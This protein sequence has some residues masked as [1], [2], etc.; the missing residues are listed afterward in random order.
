MRKG[1][2]RSI[3]VGCVASLLAVGAAHTAGAA[4]GDA[5]KTVKIMVIAE[6]GDTSFAFL[7]GVQKG[8]DAAVKAIEKAGT[9]KFDVTTCDAHD[10]VNKLDECAQ[11]AVDQKFAAVFALS[12]SQGQHLLPILEKGK[13]PTFWAATITSPEENSEISMLPTS[14]TLS[15][16]GALGA[17]AAINGFKK[18]AVIM[19]N[20]LAKSVTALSEATYAAQGGKLAGE[21]DIPIT[22]PG[23]ANAPDLAPKAAAVADKKPGVVLMAAAGVNFVQPL[24]EAGVDVP[25]FLVQSTGPA[26]LNDPLDALPAELTKNIYKVSPFPPFDTA[27][28]TK[29]AKQFKKEL[30]AIG[31]TESSDLSPY[32]WNIWVGVHALAEVVPTMTGTIDGTTTLAAL[33]SAKDVKLVDG[34]AWTPS[35]P[36]PANYIR[37]STAIGYVSKYLGNGKWKPA[38]PGPNGFV[39]D[40]SAFG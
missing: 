11:Q 9:V 38:K 33:N 1:L 23:A 16:Y 3:V 14:P 15:T 29:A 6:S 26:D 5:P 12:F 19:T 10:N 20:S 28:P 21:V 2:Y 39:M 32:T 34:H 7:D 18:D 30:K 37:S 31:A 27:K 24:R 17:G 25:L 40:S 13:I 36:G 8:V 4:S 22:I 35:A